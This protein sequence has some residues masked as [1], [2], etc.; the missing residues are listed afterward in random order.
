[1]KKSPSWSALSV[2][3]SIL[4]RI[5]LPQHLINNLG[6]EGNKTDGLLSKIRSQH[7]S[8]L[9]KISNSDLSNIRSAR[10][11]PVCGM[12][13]EKPSSKEHNL[14]QIRQQPAI[15]SGLQNSG[16]DPSDVDCLCNSQ[17][18]VTGLT[19]SI[20]QSCDANDQASKKNSSVLT[21]L[22]LTVYL[23]FRGD[24][25]WPATLSQYHSASIGVRSLR[26]R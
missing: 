4:N 8:Y 1:M 19:T 12:I 20:Q 6:K 11:S 3:A 24:P 10:Y 23:C 17:S 14:N 13:S 25:I 2:K 16:C 7:N 18:F 26:Q 15:L 21:S 5:L 9:G 22:L